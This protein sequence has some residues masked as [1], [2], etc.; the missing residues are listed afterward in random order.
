MN[1]PVKEIEDRLNEGV[2]YDKK[3]GEPFIMEPHEVANLIKLI[4]SY[5]K[6]LVCIEEFGQGHVDA[7]KKEIF[8]EQPKYE[9]S[10]TSRQWWDKV[11]GL[12]KKSKG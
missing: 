12:Q 11:N 7:V 3:Y 8:G 5:E 9:L 10:E 4:R 2:Y 1:D 6:D